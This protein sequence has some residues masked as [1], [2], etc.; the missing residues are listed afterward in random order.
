[1]LKHSWTVLFLLRLRK[2]VCFVK[3]ETN[4]RTNHETSVHWNVSRC[5][6]F[7][8]AKS[9][10]MFMF[11]VWWLIRYFAF[12]TCFLKKVWEY[13]PFHE[14]VTN[15]DMSMCM[16]FNGRHVICFCPFKYMTYGNETALCLE[17]LHLCKSIPRQTS[18]VREVEGNC[19][20]ASFRLLLV[21]VQTCTDFMHFFWVVPTDI[22]INLVFSDLHVVWK[23]F[24]VIMYFT[25]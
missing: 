24:L 14:G 6:I 2:W 5:E 9:S 4:K 11:Y 21:L 12:L 23:W 13:W 16:N 7:K 19:L 1:M 10:V 20:W 18:C 17:M 15:N 3:P 8:G 25:I 22:C